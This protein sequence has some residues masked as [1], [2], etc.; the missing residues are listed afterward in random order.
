MQWEGILHFCGCNDDNGDDKL[1][2]EL[3]MVDVATIEGVPAG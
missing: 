1:D 2:I 3:A